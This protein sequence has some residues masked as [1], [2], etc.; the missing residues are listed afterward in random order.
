VRVPS[1]GGARYPRSTRDGTVPSVRD[2]PDLWALLI[3]LAFGL[4]VFVGVLFVLA[5]AA[6]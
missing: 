6:F 5:V 4:A 2:V 1:Y 3:A